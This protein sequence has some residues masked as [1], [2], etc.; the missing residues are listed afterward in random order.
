MA[1][2]RAGRA[3]SAGR[4]LRPRQICCCPFARLR[5]PRGRAGREPASGESLRWWLTRPE[6]QKILLGLAAAAVLFAALLFSRS[7]MALL[8]TLAALLLMGGGGGGGRGLGGVDRGR[9]CGR[10]L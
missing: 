8:S 6:A 2:R 4:S 9:P 5:R 1:G 7:R 10:P 3:G